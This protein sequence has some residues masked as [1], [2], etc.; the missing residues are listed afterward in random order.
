M[1][2]E[3]ICVTTCA[4]VTGA[5]SVPAVLALA[6]VRPDSINTNGVLIANTARL[7]RVTSVDLTLIDVLAH[8]IAMRPLEAMTTLTGITPIQIQTD[9][10]SIAC[11]WIFN[12]FVNILTGTGGIIE[13]KAVQTLTVVRTNRVDTDRVFVATL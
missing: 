8:P 9:Q 12:A 5:S 7:R 1:K 13:S 6:Q 10:V 2:T 11:R 3:P 4:I